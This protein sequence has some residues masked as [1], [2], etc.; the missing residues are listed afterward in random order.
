[1]H[2]RAQ[3]YTTTEIEADGTRHVRWF[4]LPKVVVE[5]R[6]DARERAALERAKDRKARKAM[7]APTVKALEAVGALYRWDKYHW[8]VRI[9]ERV[10]FEFWTNEKGGVAWRLPDQ[11]TRKG[12]FADMTRCLPAAPTDTRSNGEGK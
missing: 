7:G 2:M 3:G 8:Q 1:M 4:P 10:V 12:T 11:A 9:G 5:E 6:N